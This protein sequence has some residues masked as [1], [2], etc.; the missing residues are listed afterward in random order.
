MS[1]DENAPTPDKLRDLASAI[2][3]EVG[4]EVGER[5]AAGFSWETKSTSTDVVTEIDTWAEAAVV[6][7][8]LAARPDDGCLLYTSDAADE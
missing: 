4:S 1:N 7:R 2:A 3:L 6:E 5:R 8:L